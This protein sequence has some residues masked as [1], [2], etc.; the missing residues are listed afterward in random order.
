MTQFDL[1]GGII[2]NGDLSNVQPVTSWKDDY[3]KQN[4]TESIAHCWYEGDVQRAAVGG[5]D[6]PEVHRRLEG[7]ET[8]AARE[9]H[10]GEGAPPRGQAGAGRP[11][12]RCSSA[13]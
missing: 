3:L 10:V 2:W 13:T 9:V 8:P 6:E 7:Q 1:P 11:S 5:A 4:V 12:R